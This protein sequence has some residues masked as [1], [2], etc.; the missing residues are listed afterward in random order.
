MKNIINLFIDGMKFKDQLDEAK[1]LNAEMLE[2]L[3]M[4]IN[5]TNAGTWDCLP[6]EKAKAAID[7][8]EGR[9]KQS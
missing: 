3:K 5:E 2:A 4:I 1:A 7:K 8:A 9:T 6:V